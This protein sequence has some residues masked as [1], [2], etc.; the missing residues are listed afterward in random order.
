MLSTARAEPIPEG[1]PAREAS[2]VSPATA[3]EPGIDG[4]FIGRKPSP[5]IRQS[6]GASPVSGKQVVQMLAALGGI[7]L[8]IGGGVWCLRRMMPGVRAVSDNRLI[9]V[10]SRAAV[11][12]K[13]SVVLVR[14]GSRLVLLGVGSDSMQKLTEI[15]ESAEV[16]RLSFHAPSEVRQGST[17]GSMVRGMVANLRPMP[18]GEFEA[19]EA[20]E[21]RVR[22]EIDSLR[23]KLSAW[24]EEER[25][26]SKPASPGEGGTA[27]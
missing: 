25:V 6:A 9:E 3:P 2:A 16:E 24:E 10:L 26:S 17:F 7:L 23:R 18:I 15:H 4:G 1:S 5:E 20:V 14:V 19:E 11:G 8:L 21:F 12:P 13:Q 22:R 27:G